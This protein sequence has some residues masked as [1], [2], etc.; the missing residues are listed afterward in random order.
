MT[1]FKSYHDNETGKSLAGWRGLTPA[2]IFTL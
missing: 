1:F 2:E